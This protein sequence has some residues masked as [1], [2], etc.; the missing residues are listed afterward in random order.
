MAMRPATVIVPTLPNLPERPST[1]LVR[2]PEE[3]GSWAHREPRRTASLRSSRGAPSS[4]RR[5][6]RCSTRAYVPRS[7][8]AGQMT[9]RVGIPWSSV[10]VH[11][12]SPRRSSVKRSLIACVAL[13]VT[14]LV[15]AP[16]AGASQVGGRNARSGAVPGP[17]SH[18]RQ[19]LPSP[20]DH[21]RSRD[22]RPMGEPRRSHP[23]DDLERQPLGFREA[24]AGR[25]VPAPVLASGHVLVPLH[26]PSEHDGDDHR[27]LRTGV[28]ER[29]R[30]SLICPGQAA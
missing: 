15:L 16:D 9:P 13:V 10:V 26:G 5:E 11:L 18:P 12:P 6:R 8:Q 21:H 24:G 29:A 7:T 14:L 22:G 19:P 28:R 4:R 25:G 30:P 27:H 1:L 2:R 3:G 17:R 20:L 23:H